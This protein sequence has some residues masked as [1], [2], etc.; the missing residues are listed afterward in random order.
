MSACLFCDLI[1]AHKLDLL[2]EDSQV[3]AFPDIEPKAPVHLLVV[4]KKHISSVAE[5][6]PEDEPLLGH[7][8]TVAKQLANEK[9]IAVGGFRTVVNTGSD[10]GQTVHHIHMHVLGGENLGAMNTFAGHH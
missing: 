5:S 9:N 7:L 1:A 4:P 10:A 3:V 2:Y 8:F 6:Q